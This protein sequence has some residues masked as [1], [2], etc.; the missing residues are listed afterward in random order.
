MEVLQGKVEERISEIEKKF[1]TS[2]ADIEVHRKFKLQDVDV[3]DEQQNAFKALCNEFKDIFSVDS[4]D[5]RKTPLIE[6]EINTGD[7]PPI[8]QKPYTLPLKH[9]EWV[10]KEL[11]ILEK[12]GVIV[13]SVSPWAS[14]IVIIPKR[15]APGEPPKRR[16]YIDYWAIN[17]LLPPVKKAFSK[18]KGILTL[19]PLLKI[20]EIYAQ[21]K[22]SKIYSTFDMR[23]GY[24]HM[25]LSEKSRPKSA[26]VSSFG[27]WEFK[28][29]PFGLAQAPAYFQRLVNEFLSCLTF[30]FG[31]LDDILVFSPD[32]EINTEHLIV[33]FERL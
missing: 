27:K 7:S 2:P 5:I 1:I 33:L 32:M 20:N 29:C 12:A 26:F 17:S 30:A 28:R 22:G 9:A 19:V 4:S 25:V 11:E 10:Q 3:P 31:Y 16:L 24:Y 18:V 13:R 21:L 14:P 6:M 8:T 15:T 23:S